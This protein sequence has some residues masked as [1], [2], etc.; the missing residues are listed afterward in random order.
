MCNVTRMDEEL[1]EAV[2]NDD[3]EAVT[4]LL[5]MGGDVNTRD[6]D[7]VCCEL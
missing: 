5:E 4:R 3:N 1:F 6:E 2:V 7:G